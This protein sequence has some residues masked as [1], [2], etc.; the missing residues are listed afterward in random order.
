MKLTLIKPNIGRSEHSLYVDE[1]RMEPLPLGVI[2]GVTPPDVEVVMYDDRMEP[3]PYDEPTDL[4]AITAQT[5]TARRAYEISAEFRERGIPTIIGG[6][7]PTL[8]PE[9]A[10]EHADSIYIG[11][12]EL[13]WPQT[14]EDARQGKLQPVYRARPGVPQ[15]GIL[16]R[17]DIFKGKGYLPITL[18]QFS[19]GCRFACDFCAISVF[20]DR[21]QF[22]RRVDEVIQEIQAQERRHLFFVDDNILSDHKAAKVLF[23]EL[24]PLRIRWVSQASIDMTQDLEL[25]DLMVRSGCLGHVIG[26]ESIDTQNLR[27]MNKAPNLSESFRDYKPQLEI[28]RDYGLQ[29]WA[30]FTLGY[31]HE[32]RESIERTLEFALES[33][34]AFAAFNVLMPYPNTPLYKRLQAEGRLLYDGKWWLHP[35]YRF[36]HAA[37]QPKLMSADEL[38]EAGFY[39]RST[40]NSVGSIIR[41]AFDL[42]TNMRSLFRLGIYAMYNPLFR[43]ETFKKH[44]LRFGLH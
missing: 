44:G 6:M 23:R 9:E 10:A 24:I 27:A 40:Y 29:T 22:C 28:L 30:A 35:A 12:A 36:N 13:L 25:L 20:F 38:T 37:F 21:T 42:K 2:A 39:A 34:F 33:K 3:I 8:I 41:R 15:P 4:V 1:G 19:R 43:K 17:R 7:H 11:D 14:V 5:F 18:I 32:T 16:P 26:F 31:D